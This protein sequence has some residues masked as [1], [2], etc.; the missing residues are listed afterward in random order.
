[1][2]DASPVLEPG[3][4]CWRVERVSRAAALIDGEAYF[5]ALRQSLLAARR[6]VLILGWDFDGRIGLLPQ[7]P[8]DGAPNTL[9]DLLNHCTAENPDLHVRVLLW[10]F[11]VLYAFE[12]EPLPSYSLRAKAGDRVHVEFD[13]TI[14]FGGS[15]HQKVVV[16]DDAVAFAGGLDLTDCRRDSSE[17]RPRDE[18]RRTVLGRPYQPF[19]DVQMVVDG[20]AAKALGDLARER[21]RAATGDALPAVD[22]GADPWP[23]AVE[24]E[25]RDAAVGI[26]RTI[27]SL[28]GGAGVHEVEELMVAAVSSARRRVYM[29]NQYFTSERLA[30]ALCERLGDDDGPEVVLVMPRTCQGW[31]EEGTM[32]TLR[33]RFLRRLEGCDRHGR[34]AAVMPVV[35]DGEDLMVHAKVTVVDDRVCVIGSSNNTKRSMGVDTEC[36]LAVDARDGDEGVARFVARVRE[37]LLGEHLGMDPDEVRGALA[38]NP[39]ML[40]L[41]RAPRSGRRRLEPVE[42]APPP[43]PGIEQIAERVGDPAA[44]LDAVELVEEFRDTVEEYAPR[45]SGAMGLAALAVVVAGL[46]LAWQYTPLAEALSLERARAWLET[47]RGDGIGPLLL[48]VAYVAAGLMAAPITLVNTATVIVFGPWLGFA[49]AMAGSL[50]SAAGCFWLG[51]LVGARSIRRLSSGVVH[52]VASAIGNRGFLSVLAVR[53][54][55]VAPFTVINLVAGA[56]PVRFVDF[57]LGTLAGMLP[58]TAL[59]AMFGDRVEKVLTDPSAENLVMLGVLLAAWVALGTLMHHL[60]ER[61]L[62]SRR[63]GGDRRRDAAGGDAAGD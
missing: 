37:R 47:L 34:L 16:V 5:A 29:E 46:A 52:R 20:A 36:N 23:E 50:L 41:I 49:Y 26:A 51:R 57:V 62:P 1:M 7:D 40:A 42:E 56:L 39:S 30:D 28:D 32:G 44:P 45:I 6:E 17:H 14:P 55:P 59:L 12:R 10:D 24:P 43:R 54:V 22:D 48:M 25:L 2:N 63:A 61:L 19:H 38:E 27:P 53:M 18:R 15:H 13:G 33:G 35:G 31:L 11:A 58:G 21:W 4:T 60:V 8:R 3:R 9:L